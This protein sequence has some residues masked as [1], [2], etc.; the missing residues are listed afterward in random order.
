[1]SVTNPRKLVTFSP[2]TARR[3]EDYRFGERIGSESE[4]LRRLIDI[5]LTQVDQGR[6]PKQETRPE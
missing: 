4:A 3:I 2:E 5:G 1:M 6:M